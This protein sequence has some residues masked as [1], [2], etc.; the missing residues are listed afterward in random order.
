MLRRTCSW[1]HEINP[2]ALRR[3]A[4]PRCHNCGH[5]ADVPRMD[6][7]CSRCKP[8]GPGPVS[9]VAT[10]GREVVATAESLDALL[11]EVQALMSPDVEEDVAIWLGPVNSSPSFW[12]MAEPFGLPDLP[13]DT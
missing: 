13:P 8:M 12:P 7:D 9:Y 1:C 4:S 2:S 3:R 11:E 5:R 10:C 6:C